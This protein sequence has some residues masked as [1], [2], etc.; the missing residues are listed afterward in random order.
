MLELD[1]LTD[2][3]GKPKAV[4]IPIELWNQLFVGEEVSAEMLAEALKDYVLNKAM[5]EAKQSPLVNRDEAL[6]FLDE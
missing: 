4:V 1:Y 6:S 5:D 2:K 3:S